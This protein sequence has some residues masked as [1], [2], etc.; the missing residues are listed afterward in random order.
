M[1]RNI[2]KQKKRAIS[3]NKPLSLLRSI[4]SLQEL[5]YNISQLFLHSLN[6]KNKMPEN[7]E[8]DR[9]NRGVALTR[10]RSLQAIASFDIQYR[11]GHSPANF[12]SNRSRKLP[13]HLS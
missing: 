12:I 1:R 5:S 4:K 13:N 8:P 3:L 6:R 7:E 2:E 10:Q 9:R 11:K